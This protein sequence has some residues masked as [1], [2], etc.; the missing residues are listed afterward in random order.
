MTGE[1]SASQNRQADKR[2]TTR[3]DATEEEEPRGSTAIGGH[4]WANATTN[5][6]SSLLAASPSG[7]FLAGDNATSPGLG[8]G[9]HLSLRRVGSLP[10]V[11]GGGGES[12]EFGSL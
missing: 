2:P 3:Q 6:R 11:R 4:K 1:G 5:R 10:L 9:A 7:S 8:G 12:S